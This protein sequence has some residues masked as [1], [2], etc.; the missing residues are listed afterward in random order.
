[1]L[2]AFVGDRRAGLGHRIGIKMPAVNWSRRDMLRMFVVLI[3]CVG[4]QESTLRATK[5][6][7]CQQ[8]SLVNLGSPRH[9]AKKQNLLRTTTVPECFDWSGMGIIRKE[10]LLHRRTTIRARSIFQGILL[11]GVECRRGFVTSISI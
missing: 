9:E 3:S 6:R 2:D 7:D 10:P 4:F 1:V 8:L 5:G 11:N